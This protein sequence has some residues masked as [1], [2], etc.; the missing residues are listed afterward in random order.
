MAIKISLNA[1]GIGR[2]FIRSSVAFILFISV[3]VIIDNPEA[4]MNASKVAANLYWT[5]PAYLVLFIIACFLRGFIKI[6]RNALH[7]E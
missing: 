4:P 6:S 1:K 7:E 3:F 2:Y 5:I